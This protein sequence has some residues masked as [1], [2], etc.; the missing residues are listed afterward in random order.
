MTRMVT[1]DMDSPSVGSYET[2]IHRSAPFQAR[3]ARIYGS[4]LGGELSH[5]AGAVDLILHPPAAFLRNYVLRRGVTQGTV[6]FVISAI[7]VF[8]AFRFVP[9]DIV[10]QQLAEMNGLP[11]ADHIGRAGPQC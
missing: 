1:I 3:V 9:G 6:G 11:A 7:M 2:S 10:N 5:Q 8:V 4:S